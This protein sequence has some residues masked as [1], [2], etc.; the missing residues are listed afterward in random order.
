MAHHY[1]CP[2]QNVTADK[3]T[4]TLT[5]DEAAHL[6]RVLRTK[7]GQA[8]TCFDGCGTRYRCV[9]T[10]VSEAAVS[11]DVL[12]A[13][14]GGAEPTV[15]VTLYVGYPKGDKLEHIIQKATE[16][17]AVR[18]VPFFSRYCVV[19][20]KKEEQKNQRY[21]RIAFEAVKQSARDRV[22]AVELPLTFAQLLKELPGYDAALF[23]YEAQSGGPT[24]RQCCAAAQAKAAAEGRAPRIAIVTGSEGGFSAE[25]AQAAAAAGGSTVGLGPR[26]LRCETAPLAA[27]TAVMALTGNLE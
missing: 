22:P 11:C 10:A 1:F 12:A 18:I 17:G 8:L 4:L 5:G 6:A 14:P 26:I 15:E 16:L 7:P 2:P 9:V 20:P 25:E 19:T 3:S 27:L 23:C 13:A 24:L 21:N